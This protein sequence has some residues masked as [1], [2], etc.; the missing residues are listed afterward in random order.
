MR[1]NRRGVSTVADVSLGILVVVVAMGVLVTAAGTESREHDPTDTAYAAQT[2]AGSTVNTT[3]SLGPAMETYFRDY[4]Q[5]ANPYIEGELRRVSHGPIATQVAD[6]AVAMAAVDG[7]QVSAAAAD[8]RR[9]LETALWTRLRGSQFDLSVTA[10]WQPVAGVNLSG[11]VV[12]G[13]TP[14]PDADVS[15]K[16]VTVPSGLPSAREESIET[17]DGPGDYG[18]VAR[19][20]ANATVTGLFPPLETQRALERTGAEADFVRYRYERLA[21]VLDGDRTLFE[22]RDWLSP[23]SADAAA[24]NEYLSRRL[25]ATLEPQLDDAYE[26]A[27][28]AARTASVETVTLTL[29][30]WTHE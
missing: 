18:A 22:R 28:D 27:Q 8:Y 17:I 11:E 14:P 7:T 19:A 24:A 13:E 2:I 23:S 12:L 30:T 9:A 16:T 1:D 10:H 29:R 26:S 21:R 15:T 20:V 25:A 6:L 4:R 5:T 3:Y